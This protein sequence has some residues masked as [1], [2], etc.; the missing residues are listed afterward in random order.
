MRNKTF[1][2][3]NRGYDPQFRLARRNRQGNKTGFVLPDGTRIR[4]T[5]GARGP[6]LPGSTVL[7]FLDI[8]CDAVDSGVVDVLVL[9]PE[10]SVDS[11]GSKELRA[12]AGEVEPVEAPEPQEPEEPSEPD[13][14]EEEPSEPEEPT[15]AK[16]LEENLSEEPTMDDSRVVE[17]EP[18]EEPAEEPVEEVEEPAEEPEEELEEDVEEEPAEEDQPYVPEIEGETVSTLKR[19]YKRSELNEIA[20]RMGL[21]SKAY[22]NETELAK[23]MLGKE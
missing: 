13:P 10:G 4:R 18:E 12:M 17:P 6:E 5:G 8:F 2:I 14:V 1:R 15:M 7:Q 23:A 21:D 16:M 20:D 3:V 19:K 9:G 22:K 11:V